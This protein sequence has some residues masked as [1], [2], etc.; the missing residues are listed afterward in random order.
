MSGLTINLREGAGPVDD[1]IVD[2]H[3]Y[4]TEDGRSVV[5]E[6]DPAGRW[7]WASPG[8]AVPRADAERLG[9][10]ER[11]AKQRQTPASKQRTKPAN[12]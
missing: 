2:R 3:L 1:V 7:L 9:A 11:P 6:G 12:K 10:V 8:T 4:L 5:E